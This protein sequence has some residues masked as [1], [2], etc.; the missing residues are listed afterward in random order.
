MS[1]EEIIEMLEKIMGHVASQTQDDIAVIIA[2][3]QNKVWDK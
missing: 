1:D 2:D 3:I